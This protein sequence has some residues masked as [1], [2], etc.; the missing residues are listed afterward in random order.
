MALH[1]AFIRKSQSPSSEVVLQKTT[2]VAIVI[3]QSKFTA[4]ADTS[5]VL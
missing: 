1:F 4:H 3:M 2:A 5:G